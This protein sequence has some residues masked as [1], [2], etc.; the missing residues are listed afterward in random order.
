M[1]SL[2]EEHR[3]TADHMAALRRELPRKFPGMQFFFQPADIVNQ[4]LNFGQQ[5]PIDIR[6]TGPKSADDYEKAKQILADLRKVPGD[7]GRPHL[8][9]ARR[10]GDESGRRPHAGRRRSGMSQRDVADNVLVT[11]IS[12][13]MVAPNFWLNPANAVSYPLVV[14]TPTYR[15]ENMQQLTPCR[16]PAKGGG[17]ANSQMLMGLADV[18]RGQMPLVMSQFNIRPVFDI[19]A[20]VQGRTWASVA[21]A[22]DRIVAKDKPDE[23]TAMHVT[24]AGQIA[25]DAARASTACSAGSAWRSCWSSC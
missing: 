18:S 7:R 17:G 13:A 2:K 5:A 10:A 23:G 11:L 12:S 3:P 8:P 20:D 19:H 1:I 25:D 15:V 6:V 16:S 14:Q 9:G 21:D 22:I 24:V 4:V